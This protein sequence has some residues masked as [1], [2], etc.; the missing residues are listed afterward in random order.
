M[1]NRILGSPQ[2]QPF[3][4]PFPAATFAGHW[5]DLSRRLELTPHR[6]GVGAGS[7]HNDR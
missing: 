3:A 1:E 2:L 6:L 5:V 4:Q 7:Y